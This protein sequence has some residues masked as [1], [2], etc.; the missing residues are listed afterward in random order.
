MRLRGRKVVTKAMREKVESA[1]QTGQCEAR[2]QQP[3]QQWQ[4]GRQRG[5]S[6]RRRGP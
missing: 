3:W 1:S 4:R 2:W 5:G 6:R